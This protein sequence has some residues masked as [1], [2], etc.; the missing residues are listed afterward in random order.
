M[1]SDPEAAEFSIVVAQSEEPVVKTRRSA[2][3]GTVQEILNEIEDSKG[4][5]VKYRVRF[6]DGAVVDVSAPHCRV[7][8][9]CA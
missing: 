1:S 6:A 5:V 3:E 8:F 9:S 7:R 4:T 2:S